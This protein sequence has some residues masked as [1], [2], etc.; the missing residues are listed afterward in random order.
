MEGVFF[1]FSNCHVWCWL[2]RTRTNCLQGSTTHWCQCKQ[3]KEWLCHFASKSSNR[4]ILKFSRHE[5]CEMWKSNEVGKCL[6]KGKSVSQKKGE[7]CLPRRK[8]SPKT[9]HK[10][11]CVLITKHYRINAEN[12]GKEKKFF[13]TVTVAASVKLQKQGRCKII[14]H[15]NDFLLF[16]R[17]FSFSRLHKQL[18]ILW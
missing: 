12:R 1:T 17:L 10:K 13:F 8:V 15:I 18:A 9:F 4:L 11:E 2:Q 16:L 14:V 3:G 7:K 5:D 6:S